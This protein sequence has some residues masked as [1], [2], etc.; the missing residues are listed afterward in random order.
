VAPPALAKAYAER[1]S[2]LTELAQSPEVGALLGVRA[3]RDVLEPMGGRTDASSAGFQQM[4][5]ESASEQPLRVALARVSFHLSADD[6][7]V[8]G[9]TSGFQPD[10]APLPELVSA[11]DAVAM[12]RE[13]L[14]ELGAPPLDVVSDPP[15]AFVVRAPL[16]AAGARP[17][18]SVRREND[19]INYAVRF[20]D[21][22]Y[23]DIGDV[24]VDIDAATGEVERVY[25]L[26]SHAA[27]LSW[28]DTKK[29]V[30]KVGP[31]VADL[32]GSWVLCTVFDG[33]GTDPD[34][35]ERLFSTSYG[36]TTQ[37]Y[38][39]SSCNEH[40][41][42]MI[43][44]GDV[45]TFWGI[46][47]DPQFDSLY[48]LNDAD[49][50][51][52]LPAN[53]VTPHAVSTQFWGERVIRYFK[54][55]GYTHRKT[56]SKIS[57]RAYVKPPAVSTKNYAE[58]TQ[59]ADANGMVVIYPPATFANNPAASLATSADPAWVAHELGHSVVNDLLGEPVGDKTKEVASIS[60]GLSDCFAGLILGDSF[61]E[62]SLQY[63]GQG[64]QQAPWK[65]T[66]GSFRG[67]FPETAGFPNLVNP[68][69]TWFGQPL[70]YTYW[71]GQQSKQ[72]PFTPPNEEQ[73]KSRYELNST[74]FGGVCKLLVTGGPNPVLSEA[75]K[76]T[77]GG[78][79]GDALA[80]GNL[81]LSA[82]R[83]GEL[84]VESFT[85]AKQYPQTFHDLIDVLAMGAGQ[86][87]QNRWALS[88]TA[89]SER[90]RRAFGEYGFGRGSEE[91]SPHGALQITS[92]AHKSENLIA[93]GVSYFREIS[94]KLC[95]AEEDFFVLNEEAR[96]G[97][98]VAYEISS[99]SSAK[100]EVRLYDD[101]PCQFDE[102]TVVKTCALAHQF[103]P[104]VNQDGATPQG[105]EPKPTATVDFPQKSGYRRVY[106][107]LRLKQPASSSG[108]VEYSLRAAITRGS[109]WEY[110]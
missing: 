54:R 36:L 108:D 43:S 58:W 62:L 87:A 102:P 63:Q 22:E 8:S 67:S 40:P 85:T 91:T 56:G 13:A 51:W 74:L 29:Q 14:L 75:F 65:L 17:A 2:K 73:E 10:I 5:V 107:G 96:Q 93:T 105:L 4:L 69:L 38:Y 61:G 78:S 21:P 19:R 12:A 57:Y 3:G 94:G 84:L 89:T 80:P 97:D 59:G 45:N 88:K 37:R 30:W 42:R 79:Y 18:S 86:L 7:S 28:S 90:V 98:S 41:E 82:E 110:P 24:V 64:E 104:Q 55:R 50:A 46:P 71:A 60:E 92:A 81:A 47:A 25:P 35:K 100:I 95:C 83:V 52:D 33:K 26:S 101:Q 109:G 44:A 103:Y 20:R 9:I 6:L 99:P 49:N 15:D 72:A 32:V 48:W 34:G 11:A 27:S 68:K 66:Y 77:G 76:E 16:P 31:Q 70:P 53:A 23:P 106:I 39:M 1:A